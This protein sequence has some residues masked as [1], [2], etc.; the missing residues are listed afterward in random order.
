MKCSQHLPKGQCDASLRIV[1]EA[2]NEFRQVWNATNDSVINSKAWSGDA[3]RAWARRVL[4]KGCFTRQT[5]WHVARVNLNRS[6]VIVVLSLRCEANLHVRIDTLT[7]WPEDVWVLC[8]L[9]HQQYVQ[10]CA[11]RVLWKRQI[12]LTSDRSLALVLNKCLSV[13]VLARWKFPPETNLRESIHQVCTSL[14]V[15]INASYSHSNNIGT[16]TLIKPND[17]DENIL[18]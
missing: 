11:A 5:E 14:H 2:Q 17:R 12:A 6:S 4:V 13:H 18:R 8:Q 15:I 7:Q 9:A 3:D 16:R 10:T 1:I